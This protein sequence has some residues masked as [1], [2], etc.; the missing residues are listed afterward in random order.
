MNNFFRKGFKY[1]DLFAGIGG[2]HQAMTQLNGTCVFAA[3]IQLET[4]KLYKKNYKINAYYDITK[5]NPKDIPHHDVLCAGFPCQS[6]SKAGSQ[7]GFS[8]IR[9]TLFFDIVRILQEHIM[10]YGGPKYVILENVRNI[11]S[12]DH[13]NT[14]KRIKASLTELGYK[15]L[16]TPLIA[17]PHY[18]EIPQL[19]ERAMILA[20]RSD[21]FKGDVNI[22]IEKK[23]KNIS[24]MESIFSL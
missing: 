7:K 13:G 15:V 22:S 5:V 24:S 12:H 21:L 14:W 8:D 4:A 1:I 23:S 18:F 6:F 17:S 20:V 10:Q 9:G 16:D 19:R 3:E 11:I 2:F